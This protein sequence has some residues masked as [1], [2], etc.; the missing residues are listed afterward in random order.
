MKPE[1]I[2]LSLSGNIPCGFSNS[3][4]KIKTDVKMTNLLYLL[5]S[6][7]EMGTLLEKIRIEKLQFFRNMPFA[8]WLQQS[9]QSLATLFSTAFW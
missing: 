9:S 4:G 2:K 6:L 1:M 3:E 5:I 8:F 7:P